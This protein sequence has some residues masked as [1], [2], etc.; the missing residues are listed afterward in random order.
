VLKAAQVKEGLQRRGDELDEEIRKKEREIRALE[1][2]LGHLLA[3][4]KKF[5]ENFQSANAQS[6]TEMEEKQMLEEQSQAASEVLFTRRRELSRLEREEQE[7]ARRYE[8]LQAALE[9]L[10][11]QVRSLESARDMMDQEM[12]Q[13]EPR[14]ERAIRSWEEWQNKA[15]TAGLEMTQ[16]SPAM[17][18]LNAQGQRDR[19][20]R[21]LLALSNV[22]HDDAH[23]L[24]LFE[25]L[26]R[27][28]GVVRP[29]RPPT[30]GSRPA[31][32]AS[33]AR[34]SSRA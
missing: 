7:D 12:Q 19:N 32:G 23:V 34:P 10:A 2:T 13:H 22:L 8:E 29:S 33:S 9:E 4:N 5:K 21:V 14:L 1:N 20:K 27:E 30:P 25:S 28:R 31:S 26:C 3:R 17:L 16:D 15:E 18:D 6:Q 24:Q 11:T